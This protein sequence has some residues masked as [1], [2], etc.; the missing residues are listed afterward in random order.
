MSLSLNAK[1][2]QTGPVLVKSAFLVQAGMTRATL[3]IF[4]C[5]DAQRA[6]ILG[7]VDILKMVYVS[8]THN[9]SELR[10]EKSWPIV[11]CFGLQVRQNMLQWLKQ[12]KLNG[13]LIYQEVQL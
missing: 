3:V 8:Q 2:N 11:E 4:I 10:A 1:E 13:I 6:E 12:M 5:Q 9:Y 7:P